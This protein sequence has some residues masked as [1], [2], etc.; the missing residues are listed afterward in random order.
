MDRTSQVCVSLADYGEL[1]RDCGDCGDCCTRL[2][3]GTEEVMRQVGSVVASDG[4]LGRY[5]SRWTRAAVPDGGGGPEGD[6]AVAFTSN[7]EPR[8]QMWSSRVER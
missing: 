2:R 5:E 7:N 1:V 6:K 8:V 4:A 3:G